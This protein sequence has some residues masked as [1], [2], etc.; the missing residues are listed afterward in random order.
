MKVTDK[1]YYMDNLLAKN[2]DYTLDR[3][4]AGW[5]NLCI[6]DGDEGSGKTTLSWGIGYYLA[7]KLKK[8]FNVKDNIYF[9]VNRLM[10]KAA[11]STNE[12]L[13]WDE[14][15]IDGLGVEWRNK[16]QRK[17]IKILMVARKKN[18]YWIFLIPK[19]YK[20][21]EYIAVDRSFFLIHVYSED[22]ISRGTYTFYNKKKKDFIY[23]VHKRQ[24]KKFYKQY[25]FAGRFTKQYIKL[26]DN[27]AYEKKK[28]KAIL[29]MFKDR[30]EERNTLA[31]RLKGFC[32]RW[33]KEDARFKNELL[34]HASV[35]ERTVQNWCKIPLETLYDKRATK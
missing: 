3:A 12:I 33:S 22:N 30:G 10:E 24:H 1:Q 6:I 26:V 2:L 19:F 7:W 28:D 15:A 20:L 16:I 23:D 32:G 17:L 8:Q 5:D 35:T 25:N 4:A 29:D 13:I 27:V 34:F 14:A 18:H 21:N 31:N 9:D 11:T